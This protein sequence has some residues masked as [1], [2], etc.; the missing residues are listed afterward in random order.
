MPA[1]EGLGPIGWAA[2]G[3]LVLGILAVVVFGFG[4]AIY[5]GLVLTFVA[6]GLMIALCVGDRA[7]G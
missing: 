7:P 1:T 4:A 5:L 2:L 3:V 6:L